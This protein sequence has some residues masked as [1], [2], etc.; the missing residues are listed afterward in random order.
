MSSF[1]TKCSLQGK[2]KFL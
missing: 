2:W 1:T